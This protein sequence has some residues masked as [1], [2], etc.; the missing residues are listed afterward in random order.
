MQQ[1]F[2]HSQT[3]HNFLIVRGTVHIFQHFFRNFL[4][5]KYLVPLTFSWRVEQKV[6]HT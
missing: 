4:F 3:V 2:A 5:H 1:K 6:I